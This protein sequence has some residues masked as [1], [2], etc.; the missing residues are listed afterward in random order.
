MD[1]AMHAYLGLL[2][3]GATP[4]LSHESGHRREVLAG[5]Q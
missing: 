5:E 3:A 1:E 2:G 4:M